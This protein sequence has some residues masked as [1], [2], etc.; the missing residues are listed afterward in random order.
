[1]IN[2]FISF[3]SFVLMLPIGGGFLLIILLSL[4]S[5]IAGVIAPFWLSLLNNEQAFNHKKALKWTG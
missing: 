1:M 5:L 2:T 3:L 4:A